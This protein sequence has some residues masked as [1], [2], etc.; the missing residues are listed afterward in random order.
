MVFVISVLSVISANPALNP[1]ACGCLSCL[2]H[3]R[4]FRDSRRSREKH[5]IAKPRFRNARFKGA[6][7]QNGVDLSFLPCCVCDQEGTLLSSPSL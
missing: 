3:F 4:H 7:G 1:L 2:R 6:S 5:R